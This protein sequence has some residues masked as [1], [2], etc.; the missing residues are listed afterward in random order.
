MIKIEVKKK[1][2]SIVGHANFSE[3]GKDIVCAAVSSVVITSI[4]A[5]ASFDTNSVNIIKS[6]DKLEIIINKDDNITTTLIKN[7]LNCLEELATKYPKNI[8]ITNK[9]E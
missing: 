1:S 5:M 8:K 6:K 9:E 7:M 3:Y 2:I 4:E